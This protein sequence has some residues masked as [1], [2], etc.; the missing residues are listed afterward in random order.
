MTLVLIVTS[1][2][3][4]ISRLFWSYAILAV[5]VNFL[6]QFAVFWVIQTKELWCTGLR[7]HPPPASDPQ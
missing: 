6:V 3:L 7:R 2:V 4:G 1:L 5:E